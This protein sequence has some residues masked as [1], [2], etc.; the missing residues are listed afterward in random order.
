MSSTLQ[1]ATVARSVAYAIR[2]W[3]RRGPSRQTLN[4]DRRLH[5]PMVQRR[6]PA[7]DATG[8]EGDGDV[9]MQLRLVRLHDEQVVAVGIAHM[10]TDLALG[11]DPI[12]GDDRA[13]QGPL[14]SVSAAPALYEVA[15]AAARVT[16]DP[17]LLQRRS[18]KPAMIRASAATATGA[19]QGIHPAPTRNLPAAAMSARGAAVHKRMAPHSRLGIIPC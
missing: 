10:A 8:A 13:L 14:S 6:V 18:A 3:P 15:A 17:G 1:S 2:P 5:E 16:A 19:A 4:V 9:P 7:E 11:E 12:A